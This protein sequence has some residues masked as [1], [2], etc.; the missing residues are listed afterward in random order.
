M[1]GS[2]NSS[3]S[4]QLDIIKKEAQ[5]K[6]KSLMEKAQPRVMQALRDGDAREFVFLISDILEEVTNTIKQAS[7]LDPIE[8]I[9]TA[10]S[11][12]AAYTAV[13][14][15]GVGDVTV[16][17]VTLPTKMVS[18]FV[19]ALVIKKSLDTLQKEAAKQVRLQRQQ[20]ICES[21]SL[22][23]YK[24][25]VRVKVDPV[26]Q[27]LL[28]KA[29]Y[30]QLQ[31]IVQENLG[32]SAFS[33]LSKSDR[34]GYALEI[35]DVLYV[36]IL[37]VAPQT[38]ATEENSTAFQE[39]RKIDNLIAG[40]KGDDRQLLRVALY[41]LRN[42]Y[43]RFI[44]GQVA[45]T[46]ESLNALKSRVLGSIHFAIQETNT[47]LKVV[48]SAQTLVTE[49][50]DGIRSSASS[51][52]S[53]T[54]AGIVKTVTSN[55]QHNASNIA[56]LE[57]HGGA[58]LLKAS[59]TELLQ[60]PLRR[61]QYM[62]TVS[63]SGFD[64]NQSG[65]LSNIVAGLKDLI[66][67]NG[68]SGSIDNI[69]TAIEYIQGKQSNTLKAQYDDLLLKTVK[70]LVSNYGKKGIF[71]WAVSR[72]IQVA[73][74]Y[75]SAGIQK[76]A[77]K[78]VKTC[79]DELL[80][81]VM[82]NLANASFSAD[83]EEQ[84]YQAYVPHGFMGQALQSVFGRGIVPQA[85][86]NSSLFYTIAK[87]PHY[88]LNE[89][90]G[91]EEFNSVIV[92]L[93]TWLHQT[94]DKLSRGVATDKEIKL[95]QWKSCIHS[96]LTHLV[97]ELNIPGDVEIPFIIGKVKRAIKRACK[98]IKRIDPQDTELDQLNNLSLDNLNQIKTALTIT[99]SNT[100]LQTEHQGGAPKAIDQDAIQKLADSLP[101]PDQVDAKDAYAAEIARAMLASLMKVTTE[102]Q[103]LTP[104]P[105]SIL[106]LLRRSSEPEASSSGDEAEPSTPSNREK[107]RADK[108][109]EQRKLVE[110]IEALQKV[111]T[112]TAN[113]RP[114]LFLP[115]ERDDRY[116][117]QP[118]KN[119]AVLVKGF[120]LSA[121]I[122]AS[123]TACCAVAIPLVCL[124]AASAMS[125]AL[126]ILA[127]V[128]AAAIGVLA[129][130]IIQKTF[131]TDQ[132]TDSAKAK[133]RHINNLLG[134]IAKQK[135][136]P[137]Q[138]ELSSLPADQLSKVDVSHLVKDGVPAADAIAKLFKQRSDTN[139]L[140]VSLK[141]NPYAQ[142]AY[143]VSVHRHICH[144]NYTHSSIDLAKKIKRD[145]VS[146]D[147]SREAVKY[148]VIAK[149]MIYSLVRIVLANDTKADTLSVISK[150]KGLI[151]EAGHESLD[152]LPHLEHRVACQAANIG[153]QYSNN[154]LCEL[155]SRVHDLWAQTR[156]FSITQSTYVA[157]AHYTVFK[158]ITTETHQ[159]G[160]Q[161]GAD[162][163]QAGT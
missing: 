20:K 115:E 47:N 39:I 11:S 142:I 112:A 126:P 113:D 77:A 23:H 136:Q 105:R 95:F 46:I 59:E 62:D 139:H 159:Q 42:C 103:K 106:G 73:D 127:V 151:E 30:P 10:L 124:L 5:K 29:I 92:N 91:A 17:N 67:D 33:E 121:A 146:H 38:V 114:I 34:K 60:A 147:E 141:E 156:E 98:E 40:I 74:D 2:A 109:Q 44:N 76:S 101:P 108:E 131:N 118:N 78:G 104:V 143:N 1:P 83:Q 130:S 18:T 107:A 84:I 80:T 150:A 93:S 75:A 49:L 161:A 94:R 13:D 116:S 148:K 26:K 102:I 99:T 128:A 160:E 50:A 31:A 123:V 89:N 162:P 137:N 86:D 157:N 97:R 145:L 28:L 152:N 8:I 66:G 19:L 32:D 87:P 82:G 3:N 135:E 6:A 43:V 71:Q 56:L 154:D 41:S 25:A 55:Y 14:A 12:Y 64:I 117:I 88:S 58:D 68:L 48:N 163:A 153:D 133:Y 90:H 72:G 57:T 35:N 22:D 120:T 65:V 54:V 79:I 81:R 24:S 16:G 9:K 15:L 119:D 144:G 125:I 158:Q 7:G 132:N 155:F 53:K 111:F 61:S 21:H 138:L 27:E 85:D 63:V 122:T 70:D 129:T 69:D 37:R 36:D 45:P 140:C 4:S 134:Y 51:A 110:E 100:H 149:D 96:L 52:I